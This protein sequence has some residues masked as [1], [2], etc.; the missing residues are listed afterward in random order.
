MKQLAIILRAIPGSGKST[1]ASKLRQSAEAIGLTCAVH[2]SDEKFM[3]GGE[4][5]FDIAKLGQYH[6]QNLYDFTVSMSNHINIVICDNTNVKASDYR[7]YIDIAKEAGYQTATVSFIPSDAQLHFSRNIH[8]V[9]ID[10]IQA[11]IE[12]FQV[13]AEGAD[14][15]YTMPTSDGAIDSE[16]CTMLIA[17][18][19]G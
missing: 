15:Q 2:S 8:D 10:V 13:Q 17:G 12:Q 5:H 19:L 9:P 16:Y 7:P 3:V 6:R 18:I 11:K 1:F 14:E 4:Y